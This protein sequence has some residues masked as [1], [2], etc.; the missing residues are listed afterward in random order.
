MLIHEGTEPGKPVR[1]DSPLQGERAYPESKSGT[2]QIIHEHHGS[3]PVVNLRLASVHTDHCDSIPIAH[4][5]Q[6]IFERRMTS[7]V[8][9]G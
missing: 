2:E 7:H 9:P 3:I 1:E 5:I 8:F 6:R 4:Q